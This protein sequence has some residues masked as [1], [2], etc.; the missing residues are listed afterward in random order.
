MVWSAYKNY[1]HFFF[2]SRGLLENCAYFSTKIIDFDFYNLKFA[3]IFARILS[4]FFSTIDKIE[5]L[6]K[7]QRKN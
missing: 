5:K 1:K 6:I 2:T 7:M 4:L 3:L